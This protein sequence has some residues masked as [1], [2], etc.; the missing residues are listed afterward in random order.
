MALIDEINSSSDF[1]LDMDFAP[2]EIQFINNYTVM[3]SRSAYEDHP[4]P[5]LRRDLIRL[6]LTIDRDLGIPDEFAERGLT[7]RSVAFAENKRCG[8]AIPR[9]IVG[10]ANLESCEQGNGSMTDS[11]A[12]ATIESAHDDP[13]VRVRNV[14]K[15]F[16]QRGGPVQALQH[17]D[18]DIRR[19]EF[20]SLL[21]P[22]GCGKS[23]LL[24]I[25]GGLHDADRRRGHHRRRSTPMRPALPSSTGW[26]RSRR[27]SCRGRRSIRTS[28]SSAGCTAA[29]PPIR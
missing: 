29:R 17:V 21:G 4:D 23:T 16:R 10:P 5:A 25:I 13:L 24:R 11:R 12:V 18:L 20:V 6:W 9:R 2:G 14:T 19:G 27:R 7:S 28:A 1:H 15:V 8:D 22:S 3:H 26:S